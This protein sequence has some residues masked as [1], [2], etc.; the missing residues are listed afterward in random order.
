MEG[1]R[2]IHAPQA[3]LIQVYKS[4][5]RRPASRTRPTCL[6]LVSLHMVPDIFHCRI[7]HNGRK[8]KET[9]DK[10]LHGTEYKCGIVEKLQILRF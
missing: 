1:V 2:H 9:A 3:L 10:I 8:Q 7:D 4:S 5:E 6:Y